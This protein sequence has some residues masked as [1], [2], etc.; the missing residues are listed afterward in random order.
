MVRRLAGLPHIRG[1]IDFTDMQGSD[2]DTLLEIIRITNASGAKV[3]IIPQALASAGNVRSLQDRLITVWAQTENGK[4]GII[5]AL[6]CGV[7]GIVVTDYAAAYNAIGFFRDD[8][9]TLL[10][11]PR[12]IGHRGMPSEYA[13]NT[14]MSVRGAYQAGADVIECDIYLSRDGE[15][16]INH[17]ALAQTA[18]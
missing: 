10:R 3:A 6:T 1:L 9:P 2:D 17:D 8:A 15:L 7:N 12:I 5:G 18:V 16:Y 11:L 13:E 4:A 14:L